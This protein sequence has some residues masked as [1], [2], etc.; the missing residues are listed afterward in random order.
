MSIRSV[1]LWV[2][3][4]PYVFLLQRVFFSLYFFFFFKAAKQN[5]S[6][7]NPTGR[8]SVPF[9]PRA[10]FQGFDWTKL[11]PGNQ[12][13]QSTIQKQDLMLTLFGAT[14]VSLPRSLPPPPLGRSSPTCTSPP[15]GRSNKTYSGMR[16]AV[17]AVEVPGCGRCGRSVGCRS[18]TDVGGT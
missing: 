11:G 12:S 2:H 14:F 1:L 16:S 13:Q 3:V 8:R 15:P 18:D 10:R 6:G 4:S 5:P 17:W 9:K 7:R